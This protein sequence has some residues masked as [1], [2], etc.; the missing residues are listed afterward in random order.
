[1]LAIR[2]NTIAF[3]VDFMNSIKIKGSSLYRLVMQSKKIL[4][5]QRRRNSNITKMLDA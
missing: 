3:H 5:Y 1:M 4:F 2:T